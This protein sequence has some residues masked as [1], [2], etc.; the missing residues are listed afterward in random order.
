[1]VSGADQ[2]RAVARAEAYSSRA[3]WAEAA[4]TWEHVVAANPVNGDHWERLAQARFHLAD[5]AGALAAL[6]QV[7]VLGVSATREDTVAP[8]ELRYRVAW[9]HAELGDTDQAVAA[10]CDA[11]A[12]GYRDVAGLADDERF[13]KVCGHPRFRELL[14]SVPR[15]GLGRD[16]G[17]RTNLE[18][19]ADEIRRRAPRPAPTLDVEALVAAVPRLS[20]ARIVVELTK[21]VAQLDDGHGFV[22]VPAGDPELSLLLP[23][24]FSLFPEGLFVVAA[25]PEHQDL[26]GAEV[27]RFDGREVAEVLDALGPL[28]N[29]DNEYGARERIVQVL[30]R[31]PILHALDLT[32][33][34]DRVTLGLWAPDRRSTDVTL[35][36][37]PGAW[38]QRNELPA[39]PGWL[40]FSDTS[41]DRPPLYLRNCEA[42]YWFEHL[43]EQRAVYFQFNTIRDHPHESI[44]AFAR[45][46]FEFIDRHEIERLV[47]DLR[48]NGGGNNMLVRPLLNGLTGSRRINRRGSLFV[49]I[50]RRTFSA[51]QY[52][53]TAIEAGTDAI[54]VGEPTGSR[55]NFVG[56]T[57]P[58]RLPHRG[59]RVNVSDVH[60]Q[61]SWPFDH[62]RWIAPELYAPPTFA[63]LRAG[64]DP[65]MEAITGVWAALPH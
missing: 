32:H 27:E 15:A 65:A 43:P 33:A 1:M 36:A 20:D 49:V 2:L 31:V 54:F 19:L 34:P 45:R 3:A 62:R 30:R 42:F 5:F 4:T 6:E 37:T 11:V 61:N 50:G 28:V 58:F 26:L 35:S 18:A 22:E 48:W 56:E 60:W 52:V 12:S 8:G 51:G 53:A 44:E 41:T 25:T 57:T 63:C 38:A 13:R 9:C 59:I 16:D 10:L 39:P 17:W 23:V 55:P 7:L 29:K 14:G 47:V 40:S 24:Q 46:L 21:L 64:R